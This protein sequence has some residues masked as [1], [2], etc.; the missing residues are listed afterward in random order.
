MRIL[1]RQRVEAKRRKQANDASW[2]QFQGNGKGVMLRDRGIGE[3]IHSASGSDKGTLPV[4]AEQR[5]SGYSKSFDVTRPDQRLVR[6]ESKDSFGGSAP[7][8][9]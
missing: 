1:R 5:L 9:S 7:H 6:R 2:N 4:K 8:V 3:G